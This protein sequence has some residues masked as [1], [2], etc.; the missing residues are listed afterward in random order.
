MGFSFAKSTLLRIHLQSGHTKHQYRYSSSQL[1]ELH[2][3]VI[4]WN[5]KYHHVLPHPG[6]ELM[7]TKSW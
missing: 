2:K 7:S 6:E 1:E 4:K 5:D 3:L